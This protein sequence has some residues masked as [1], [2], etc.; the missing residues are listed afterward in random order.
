MNDIFR[1]FIPV[2]SNLLF[3][4]QIMVPYFSNHGYC[5]ITN[6]FKIFKLSFLRTIYLNN[7]FKHFVQNNRTKKKLLSLYLILHKR[8]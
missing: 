6:T 5:I 8:H 4:P 3:Y 7:I 2:E 1:D